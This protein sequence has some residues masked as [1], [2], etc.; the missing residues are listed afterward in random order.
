MPSDPLLYS[1]YSRQFILHTERVIGVPQTIVTVTKMHERQ[2]YSSHNYESYAIGITVLMLG[3]DTKADGFSY[4][5]IYVLSAVPVLPSVYEWS[6]NET[7]MTIY[8]TY[9]QRQFMS[10][11]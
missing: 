4:V 1:L 9:L 11:S 8:S 10:P 5:T 6:D 3:G 2:L 7:A